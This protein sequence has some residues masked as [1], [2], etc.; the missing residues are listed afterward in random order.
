M[1]AEE[2]LRVG[3][4]DKIVPHDEVMLSAREWAEDLCKVAPLAVRA[5]KGFYTYKKP[6]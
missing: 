1:D 5:I 2:A 4:I 6:E 3:L